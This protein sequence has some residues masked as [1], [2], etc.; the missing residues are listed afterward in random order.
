MKDS[1]VSAAWAMVSQSDFEPMITPTRGFIAGDCSKDG[2]ARALCYTPV[3]F[4]MISW[5]NS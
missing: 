1:N 3:G 5:R 4:F 2:G